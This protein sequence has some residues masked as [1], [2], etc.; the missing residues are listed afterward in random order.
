MVKN[1]AI[2]W[3]D[4][5]FNPW[6]GCTKISPGCD[7]CYAEGWSKRSGL[8]TWGRDR[9]RTSAPYWT[10]PHRW[11]LRAAEHW[12]PTRVF[13]GSLCDV[14]DNQVPDEWRHD[15]WRKIAKTPALTWMLLTKRPQNIATMLPPDGVTMF[16]HTWPWPH[17][18]L[19]VTAENQAEANRRIPILLDAPAARRFVSC[20]PLLGPVDLRKITCPLCD[21]TAPLPD[22]RCSDLDALTGEWIDRATGCITLETAGLDWIICG[23]ESGP[24]ARPMHPDWARGLRDQCRAAKVPF[25]FKQWGEWLP[26]DQLGA[27]EHAG[28]ERRYLDA[29]GLECHGSVSNLVVNRIGKKAAGH[30]LDGEECQEWPA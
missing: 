18:W 6:V 30:A 1:T 19:G 17:V 20:E 16:K 25:F 27:G 28:R 11:N 9:R 21:E 2:E 8:V 4:H 5:T 13:C 26:S 23:G 29:A 24:G 7:H 10:E 3:C 22:D 12:I 14:F 15:L